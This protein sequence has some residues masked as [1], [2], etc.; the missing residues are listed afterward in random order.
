M[1]KEL[2]SA[3]PSNSFCSSCSL[4]AL[5][6]YLSL[7]NLLTYFAP[8]FFLVTVHF[9]MQTV[10]YE[11]FTKIF[12]FLNNSDGSTAFSNIFRTLMDFIYVMLIM[13]LFL[14]SLNFN[15]KHKSFRPYLYAIS[16]ALGIYM[17]VVVGT[18]IWDFITNGI[19]FNFTNIK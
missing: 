9:S 15:A 5:N 8:S 17:L 14:L 4:K 18:M 3:S 1:K 10:N 11:F 13:T 7:Q 16:T 19:C 2:N 6:F 12:S